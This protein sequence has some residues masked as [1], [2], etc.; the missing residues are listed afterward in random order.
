MVE[1]GK[2]WKPNKKQEQVL[3]LP[4]SIFEC[5][6]GGSAGAGKSELLLLLP[7]CKGLIQHPRFKGILFR[8]T[9]PELERELIL[10]SH[11]YY[12][13]AGGR[14]IDQKKR[15]TFPSGGIIQF[16]Y[17][18]HEKD[19]RLYDTAEYNY[20][21]FDECTSFTE[22][23]YMY[24]A[25]TRVRSSDE[26]LPAFVRSATN[27]GNIGHNFFRTRF[28]DPCKDGGKVLR[29]TREVE[30]EG[31]KEER[32]FLRIFVKALPQD[33]DHLLKNDPDYIFRLSRL[34]EAEKAAKLYGDWY[35]FKGQVFEDFRDGSDRSK[36]TDEPI[37]ALHVIPPFDIPSY[38]PRVLSVDW[39]YDANNV[40][41]FYV[42]NPFPNNTYP[43]KIYKYRELVRNKTKIAE[44]AKELKD[45][46]SF[47]NEE[48]ID[49]VLDPSAFAKRGEDYSLSEL[50]SL[51]SGVQFR[52][53]SNDRIGGKNLLQEYLRWKPRQLRQVERIYSSEE[54]ARIS[55]MYGPRALE[56]YKHSFSQ[57]DPDQ[58]LPK[59][60][61]F[62]TCENTIKVIAECVYDEDNP[63]DVKEFR[64]D[65]SY[66]ET[67]Y[68]L[69]A[70]QNYLD[71]G[72]SE[73]NKNEHIA[74]IE[75]ELQRTNNH[76]QYYISMASINKGQTK[77]ARGFRMKKLHTRLQG[78]GR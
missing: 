40:C 20:M 42:I 27:P 56:E 78:H 49:C 6:Y 32:T 75:A 60:Q 29:E 74:R 70:C 12:A 7:L 14:Y 23:M 37:N 34:T 41:G 63:E 24:L 2:T 51:Y 1:V 61:I 5:L 48:F 55:R 72:K 31:N 45:I 57:E 54:A 33:N 67:R 50:I 30:I 47:K 17:A 8:R 9:Y 76:T 18:E 52:K 58:F 59:F 22:F 38:W 13:P 53:A 66:D 10:R 26:N 15:W 71:T 73:Y 21:G 68:G 28:V 77:H 3:S 35:T 62:N 11:A 36:F 43:A 25:F 4:D 46:I 39:G 19:V 44:W 16:G 69:M 65:D 64:G